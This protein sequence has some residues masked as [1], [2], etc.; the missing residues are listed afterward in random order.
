MTPPWFRTTVFIV[1][2]TELL[3]SHP[4]SNP[5]PFAIGLCVVVFDPA[6]NQYTVLEQWQHRYLLQTPRVNGVAIDIPTLE[7]FQEKHNTV[8]HALT[9][10][11]AED[12]ERPDVALWK[13]VNV[14]LAIG[15]AYP[16]H[17][18][19]FCSD[20]PSDFTKLDVALDRCGLHYLQHDAYNRGRGRARSLDIDAFLLGRDS[21]LASIAPGRV[22]TNAVTDHTHTHDPLDDALELAERFV[23]ALNAD[24]R[25]SFSK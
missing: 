13:L 2:D 10:P 24:W 23:W 17:D 4:L 7:W 15:A 18:L 6:T 12:R 22:S 16:D 21:V 1:L 19:C 5:D 14:V 9:Q 20:D 8:Y 11:N 3:G 25:P